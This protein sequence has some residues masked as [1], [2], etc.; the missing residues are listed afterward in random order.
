MMIE[1]YPDQ[2]GPALFAYP[3]AKK[4]PTYQTLYPEEHLGLSYLSAVL[5]KA[6]ILH[7]LWQPHHGEINHFVRSWACGGG[8]FLGL[9]PTFE[10]MDLSLELARRAHCAAPSIHVCLGGLHCGPIAERIL[11]AYSH[12]DSVVEG[13]A[14][15]IIEPL[16]LSILSRRQPAGIPGVWFRDSGGT[17]C[18]TSVR[19]LGIELDWLPFPARP[20][21]DR[22]PIARI[23]SSRGCPRKCSYCTTPG[24]GTAYRGWRSRS[25]RDVVGEVLLLRAAGIRTV[26]FVDDDFLG[27]GRPAK[28][29]AREIARLLVEQGSPVRWFAFWCT[30]SLNPDDPDD[31]SLLAELCRS[32]LER[33]FLGVEAGS[34][35]TLKLFRKRLAVEDSVRAISMLRRFPIVPQIGFMM[36]HPYSTPN[37][38]RACIR[39]LRATSMDHAPVHFLRQLEVHPGTAIC[40]DLRRDGLLDET[41]PDGRWSYRF[42]SEIAARTHS[43]LEGL[44][45]SDVVNEVGNVQYRIELMAARARQVEWVRWRGSV[46]ELFDR[47]RALNCNFFEETILAAE[48][49]R[50]VEFARKRSRAYEHH[51]EQYAVELAAT[52]RAL[53]DEG[54]D[55]PGIERCHNDVL[56]RIE[57]S[58]QEAVLRI[59]SGQSR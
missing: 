4:L 39:F 26:T 16:V 43:A 3:P 42:R 54:F 24:R 34:D 15:A 37:E 8:R 52:E 18:H 32:G 5:Q 25:A 17:V 40:D 50:P 38:L 46:Q 47:I 35:E 10:T 21:L 23:L 41:S 28:Q 58:C 56:A 6:G 7:H 57:A 9:S 36:F 19:P 45:D 27:G 2:V 1:M 11:A 49:G 44:L 22:Q 55:G 48:S 20:S 33:V 53:L 29:R 12:V 30:D 31:N 59:S 13:E 51:L 14:E